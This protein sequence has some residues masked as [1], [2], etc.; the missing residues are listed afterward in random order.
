M[1]KSS[2]GYNLYEILKLCDGLEYR[3]LAPSLNMYHRRYHAGRLTNL[4][5]EQAA[6][7]T[8][9]GNRERMAIGRKQRGIADEGHRLLD[10]K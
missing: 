3:L 9:E 1:P 2:P 8:D 10:V 4:R 6:G 5:G 7:H